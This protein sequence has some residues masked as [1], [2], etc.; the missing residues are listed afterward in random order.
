M[1]SP[2]VKPLA[3]G[4]V[5]RP[6]GTPSA[7]R[8]WARALVIRHAREAGLTLVDVHELGDD[9]RRNADVLNRLADLVLTSGA[10]VLVTDD[11]QPALATQLVRDLGLRHEP[12]PAR[13]QR[14]HVEK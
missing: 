10:R 4:L 11:V 1:V 8:S 3:I 7:D 5:Y 2:A 6:H 13:W 9:G 14:R 12:V